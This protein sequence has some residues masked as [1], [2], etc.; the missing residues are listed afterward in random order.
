[1]PVITNPADAIV[2]CN[3]VEQKSPCVLILDRSVPAYQIT[4]KKAGYKDTT[5]EL[6]RGVNGWI[7]GNI[8]LGGLIGIVVDVCD[9]SCYAFSPDSVSQ[10]LVPEGSDALVIKT[11]EGKK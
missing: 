8:L 7:F 6:K 5:V 2:V 10:S 4:I 11:V 3:G 1:V 9:S